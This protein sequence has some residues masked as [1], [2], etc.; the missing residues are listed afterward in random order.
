MAR[1]IPFS[2][3]LDQ[4][5]RYPSPQSQ[6]I[7]ASVVGAM[8]QQETDLANK[9]DHDAIYELVGLGTRYSS[10]IV[11]FSARLQSK[12]REIEKLNEKIDILQ[13]LVQESNKKIVDLKQQNKDLKSLLASSFRLPNPLDKDGM[14]LYEKQMH[15]RDEARSLKFL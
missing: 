14:L 2:A 9:S 11:S 3:S 4:D 10:S 12:T 8:K 7:S 13:R 15:L 1:R 5:L 6:S